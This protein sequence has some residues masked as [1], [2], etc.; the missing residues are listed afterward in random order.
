MSANGSPPDTK[1]RSTMSVNALRYHR[2]PAE[3]PAGVRSSQ[4][5]KPE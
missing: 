4:A 1:D 3:H 2:P 5:K